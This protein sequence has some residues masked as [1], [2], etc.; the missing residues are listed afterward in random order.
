MQ[1][2][3]VAPGAG[4]RPPAVVVGLDCMTGLQTAHILAYRHAVPVIGVAKNRRH[5]CCRTRSCQEIHFADTGG[6]GLTAALGRLGP[7]LPARAVLYP[8]TDLSVLEISRC[9]SHLEQWYHILLPPADIVEMLVDKIGFYGFARK[10]G[11][12]VPSTFLL[13]SA[14]DVGE[15]ARQLSYPAVLKPSVKLPE[16][17]RHMS[18]KAFVVRDAGE[19]RALYDRCAGYAEAL[20]VQEWVHGDDSPNYTCNAYFGADGQPLV[21]FVTRKLREWPPVAGTGCLGQECRNDLVLQETVR[22][23]QAVRHRGFGYMEMKLDTRLGKYFLIEPNIGRPTGRSATAEAAGV[24]FLYTQYCDALGWPL[25][26][27]R[28]QRYTGVKWVYLRRDFQSALTS[29]RRG[30]LTL[31]DWLRSLRGPKVEALFSWKDPAPFFADLLKGAGVLLKGRGSK[32]SGSAAGV[33]AE[34][35]YAQATPASRPAVDFDVHGLVGVRLVDPAPG[36]V[37]AVRRQLGPL[38]GRLSGPPDI[39]VRFVDHL[40]VP[41]LRHVELGKSGFTE[42]GFYILQSRKQ[43]ARV[44]IDFQQIGGSCEIVCQTG[45]SAVPLLLAIIN[46]TLLAKECVPL[47]AS[48]FLHK[49]TGVVVTGWAKGGKTEA[50]LAFSQRGARYVGDEWVLLTADGRSAFG[51]PE[52]IRLQQWHLAQL[53]NMRTHVRAADR[54]FFR[55]VRVFERC[56]GLFPERVARRSAFVRRLRGAVPALR[57]QLNAQFDPRVVFGDSLGPFSMVPRKVFFMMSHAGPGI[58]VEP[59]D[60]MQ[61]AEHMCESIRYEQL[62]FFSNYL[63]YRF[64]FPS[65][66]NDFIEHAYDLQR[67]LLRRALSGKDAYIVRHPYPCSLDELYERMSPFCESAASQQVGDPP[68]AAS[69]LV[70]QHAVLGGFAPRAEASRS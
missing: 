47:H 48:A 7:R 51:I 56:Q 26:E 17:E 15:A 41:E 54:F 39:T 20:L 23:F 63:A 12:V 50:L 40:P 11:F 44:R 46:M 27:R 3:P 30:R 31:R 18:A 29:W 14:D 28:E 32:P 64:A 55:A 59:T 25:P 1:T 38:Q 5:P 35:P 33:L 52:H 9:R 24:D 16:W 43:P 61:V 13:R 34:A 67:Q 57:R 19:L 49:G 8:C 42:D 66:A 68:P 21:T 69:V 10:H 2:T 37:A 45:I 53:P 62:P 58:E 70:R 36:D 6:P 65:R 4:T 22:F 60:P